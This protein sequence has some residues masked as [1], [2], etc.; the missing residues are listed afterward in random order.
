MQRIEEN[1]PLARR[2]D[3]GHEHCWRGLRFE[4]RIAKRAAQ[5]EPAFPSRRKR[6]GF[7]D[8]VVRDFGRI[9]KKGLNVICLFEAHQEFKGRE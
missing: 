7:Q 4:P 8:Q 6:I 5:R 9:G 3:R 1:I 2:D